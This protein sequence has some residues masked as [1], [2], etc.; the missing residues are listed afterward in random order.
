MRRFTDEELLYIEQESYAGVSLTSIARELH[1][2]KTAVIYH[3]RKVRSAH[4]F[5]QPIIV[6]D[7]SEL[8][9][10]ILGIFA[11]DGSFSYDPKRGYYGS[12]T[13][14]VVNEKYL[15]Y[16][17]ERFELFFQ[18]PFAFALSH[19]T[20][21]KLK[22]SSKLLFDYFHNRLD[23]EHQNKTFTVGLRSLE[24]SDSFFIGFLR[25]LIDTDGT[26]YVEAGSPRVRFYT[27]SEKL[28][29]QFVMLCAHFGFPTRI[30]VITH[31]RYGH[32]RSHYKIAIKTADHVRQFL[33][34]IQPFKG[35]R[36]PEWVLK[37]N[38]GLAGFEPAISRPPAAN[39]TKLD[40]SPV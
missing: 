21:F 36:V 3:V 1:T 34:L 14:G 26:V 2:T 22:L 24:Y 30:N 10:E 35:S 15:V 39:H 38:M 31:R 6:S 12:I 32:T 8:E 25:G 13:V 5:P 7:D 37:R 9:G 11:G 20:V 28:R 40:H 27:S 29:D 33:R 17:K 18:K 19:P 23:F 16:I 4:H